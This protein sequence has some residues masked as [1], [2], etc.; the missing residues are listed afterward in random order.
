MIRHIFIY[1]VAI[2]MT[3]VR[4]IYIIMAIRH[5]LTTISNQYVLTGWCNGG[6]CVA[7]LGCLDEF[8]HIQREEFPICDAQR[9]SAG[10]FFKVN[11]MSLGVNDSP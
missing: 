11:D 5:G 2:M 6:R 9:H 4:L 7:F 1:T 8:G 10:Y 3:F